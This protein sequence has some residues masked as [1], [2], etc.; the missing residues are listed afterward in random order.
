MR[1][2]WPAAF[3]PILLASCAST[4]PY[5]ADY[6]LSREQFTS[7]DGILRGVVPQGWFSSSGDSLAPALMV[8]LLRDDFS[9]AVSVRELNV[10]RATASRIEDGGLKLLARIS[11]GLHA[12]VP[13]GADI[14]PKEFDL[15]GKKFCGYEISGERARTRVVVFAARGRFFECEARPL[16]GGWSAEDLSRIFS[17]QQTVLSTLSY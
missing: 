11:A 9:A 15:G 16:T 3:L 7:R 6:P 5:A 2:F 13:P 17:V 1:N 12:G 8:W 10:D 14:D 4:S